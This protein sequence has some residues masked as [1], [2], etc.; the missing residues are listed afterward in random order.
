MGARARVTSLFAAG[1]YRAVE[2]GVDDIPALQAFF[3]QNP[4]YF[5]TVGGQP[6]TAI[7][8]DEEM[9]DAPQGF[10]YSRKW[11]I[12]FVDDAR[13][14][15]GMADLLSDLIAPGVWHLGLFIV[16]TRLHGSG[17][18]QLLYEHL[19]GWMRGSGARWLRLGVVAGNARAERFW[20][21]QAFVEVRQRSGIAMGSRVNTV[22]V[23]AKPLSGGRLPEY[24]ALVA[25][26]RPE[27]C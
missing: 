20:Q 22:R 10:S 3:E 8:A 15:V 21:R 7:E 26:D 6:P 9:H 16:A 14:L 24:Y 17:A 13:F 12:G 1:T 11:L 19:E 27:P 4:E 23:M 25:R 5:M 18:A 2:L